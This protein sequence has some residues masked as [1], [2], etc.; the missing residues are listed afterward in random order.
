LDRYKVVSEEEAATVLL[1]AIRR[2]YEWVFVSGVDPETDDRRR[3]EV[4]FRNREPSGQWGRMVTLF[5]GLCAEAGLIVLDTPT[6]RPGRT[7]T[8]IRPARKVVAPRAIQSNHNP[9]TAAT[10][11]QLHGHHKVDPALNGLLSRF[12]DIE[13]VE[14]LDRWYAALKTV[15]EFVKGAKAPVHT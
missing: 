3:V 10:A 11:P 15:F 7:E 12:A 2:A 8:K 4:A 13:T 6:K 14:D 5:L 9:P 1:D